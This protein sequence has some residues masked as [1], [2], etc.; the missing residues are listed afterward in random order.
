MARTALP[1]RSA[2]R[3][4][5]LAPP[6]PQQAPLAVGVVRLVAE[7]HADDGGV[8]GVAAGEHLPVGDPGGFGVALGEPEAAEPGAVAGLGAVVVEDDLEALLAGVGDDLVEDLER[9]QA[10]E[11]GVDGGRRGW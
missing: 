5:S 1:A 8:V 7:I 4:Q 2:P 6:Q 10:L 11:V 3:R 9:V